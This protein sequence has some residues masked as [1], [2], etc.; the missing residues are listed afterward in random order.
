MVWFAHENGVTRYSRNDLRATEG[1]MTED[2]RQDVKVFPNPF[3]PRLQP[4]VIFD[5]VSDDAVIGVYNRGGKLV[6]S[7]S[8]NQVAGGRVE[9]DGRMNNGSLVAPGVYQYVIR[10]SSKT[11]KGKLLIIH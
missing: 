11:K 3:R 2:A 5:N 8:G 6:A 7:F 10:A 4:H 1:N 9:W